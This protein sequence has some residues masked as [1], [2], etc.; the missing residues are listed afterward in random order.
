MLTVLQGPVSFP[1]LIFEDVRE[2]LTRTVKGALLEGPELRDI[3][4]LIG[5]S[6]DAKALSP[7]LPIT[8]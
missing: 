3:S 4:S 5:L 1:S 8:N 2:V 6:Q 7:D